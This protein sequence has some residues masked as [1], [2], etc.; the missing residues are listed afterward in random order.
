MRRWEE[1]KLF[2][3]DRGLWISGL[4]LA[5]DIPRRQK[6]G[7][8]SHAHFD[9]FGRHELSLCTTATAAIYH[10]RVGSGHAVRKLAYG[11][12]IT[13][14]EHT[15]T[16][17]PSGHML[18]SAMLL[19]ERTG[20][21]LLVTGDF[22]LGP[23]ATAEANPIRGDIPPALLEPDCLIMECTFGSPELRMPPRDEVIDQ[24]LQILDDCCRR[25]VTP[26]IHAYVAGKAQEVSKIL[27]D[28]E[29]PVLQHRDIFEITSVY[30]RLGIDFPVCNPYSNK[31]LAATAVIAPPKSH[32]GFRMPGLKSIV[33]IGLTGWALLPGY[34]KKHGL[35]HALPLSDHADFD[36]LIEFVEKVKP[37]RIL[38]THG[39]ATFAEELKRR[40]Y[41]AEMLGAET[42]SRPDAK[43]GYD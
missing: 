42:R 24:L 39:P 3:Y 22:K 33:S 16:T 28:R 7:F 23:S 37:K 29:F 40:G 30:K 9:H 35:D 21:R 10:A 15:L 6:W 25:R 18:G 43:T 2:A 41:R 5:V 20:E 36:E 4:G 12:P 34:A 14:D 38:C 19:V 27:C 17:F 31:P 26:V 1:E 11:V 13:L 8:I 32:S